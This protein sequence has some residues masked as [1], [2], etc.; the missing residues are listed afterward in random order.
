MA[1]TLGLTQLENSEH[2]RQYRVLLVADKLD[3]G[4]HHCGTTSDFLGEYF[5]RAAG[6]S[7]DMVDARH[8]IGYILNEIL[9]NAVKFRETGDIEVTCSLEDHRFEARIQNVIGAEAAQKFRTYLDGIL[10][11]DPGE[12]LLERIEA[13]ALDPESGGSGLGLLTLMN[14]YD[15]RLGWRFD[16]EHANGRVQLTTVAAF[17]LS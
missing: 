17:A 11:R 5:A 13:N 9:E 1:D 6:P 7:I 3:I 4:W 8:S 16:A 12:L 14:D 10:G 2:A 15:A